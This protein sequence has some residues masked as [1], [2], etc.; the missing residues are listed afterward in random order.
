M[1][2]P[3]STGDRRLVAEAHLQTAL[4]GLRP[5]LPSHSLVVTA[6]EH[7][8]LSAQIYGVEVAL[9]RSV[10]RLKDELFDRFQSFHPIYDHDDLDALLRTLKMIAP[11]AGVAIAPN[12]IN[13][14]ELPG[15]ILVVTVNGYAVAAS[16]DPLHLLAQ[17][18]I[19]LKTAR[20]PQ[21]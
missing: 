4:S 16:E 13:L 15:A 9:Q 5:D 6:D 2:I 7:G 1:P 8:L 11:K 10:D 18:L 12:S 21:V 17:T 14:I 20:Y 3:Q 19:N